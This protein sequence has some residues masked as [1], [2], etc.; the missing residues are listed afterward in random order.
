MRAS[1]ATG[2]DSGEG[3]PAAKEIISGLLRDLKISRIAEGFMSF[4]LSEKIYSIGFL[5]FK[6]IK[7]IF[8]FLQYNTFRKKIQHLII[9]ITNISQRISKGLIYFSQSEKNEVIFHENLSI[10]QFFGLNNFDLKNF[11]LLSTSVE[12]FSESSRN[13]N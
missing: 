10:P 12:G 3:F 6:L 8:R 4:T 9:I 1:S 5:P 13:F 2:N 11:G 7:S